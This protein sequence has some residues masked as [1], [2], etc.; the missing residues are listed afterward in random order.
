MFRP[1]CLDGACGKAR[2]SLSLAL[3]TVALGGPASAAGFADAPSNDNRADAIGL[4]PLPQSVGGTTGGATTELNEPASACAATA[5]SL[6]YALTVG[7]SPPDRIGVK[8]LANGDLDAAVD[9]YQKQ[10]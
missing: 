5:G 8:L 10:R 4:S 3:A 9:V 7:S 2:W 6:W 1:N